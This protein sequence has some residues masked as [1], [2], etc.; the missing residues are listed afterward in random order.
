MKRKAKDSK[1]LTSFLAKYR[2]NPKKMEIFKAI[3]DGIRE[4]KEAEKTGKP[5]KSLSDFL[6]ELEG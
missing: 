2:N 5:L 4:V 1:R 3:R 6:N